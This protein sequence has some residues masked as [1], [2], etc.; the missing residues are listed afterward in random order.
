MVQ[1]GV[2]SPRSSS[3]KEL[4][5]LLQINKEGIRKDKDINLKLNGKGILKHCYIIKTI[6]ASTEDLLCSELFEHDYVTA[7]SWKIK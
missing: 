6:I 5:Y 7:F 4:L 1:D 2:C 3:W